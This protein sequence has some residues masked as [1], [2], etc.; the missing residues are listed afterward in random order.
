MGNSPTK[1]AACED[2]LKLREKM[3]QLGCDIA[4]R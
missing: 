1:A 3:D 4:K 2:F